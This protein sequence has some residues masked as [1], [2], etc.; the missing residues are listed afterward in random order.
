M[1]RLSHGNNHVENPDMGS[2]IGLCFGIFG[3]Q[4]PGPGPGH[5]SERA[6]ERMA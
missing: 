5:E 3:T 1:V 6:C 4:R 2:P